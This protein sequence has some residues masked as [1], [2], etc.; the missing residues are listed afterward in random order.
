MPLFCN[1]PLA[2][3]VIAPKNHDEKLKYCNIV[4]FQFKNHFTDFGTGP[5]SF[6][7]LLISPKY[8]T[9]KNR[10]YE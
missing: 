10:S 6:I 4:V 9:I 8:I 3:F 7:H 1:H 5:Y 2:I